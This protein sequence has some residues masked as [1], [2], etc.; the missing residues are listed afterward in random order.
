M[1]HNANNTV[2]LTSSCRATQDKNWSHRL[3]ECSQ[4][5]INSSLRVQWVE[6]PLNK[7]LHFIIQ[8]MIYRAISSH[9]SGPNK[10]FTI[11]YWHWKIGTVEDNKT[12]GEKGVTTE[13][14]R[15]NKKL[16]LT[17]IFYVPQK[18]KFQEILQK[19]LFL[20]VLCTC[21]FSNSSQLLYTSLHRFCRSPPTSFFTH[22]SFV[23]LYCSL[24]APKHT[25]NNTQYYVFLLP[26]TFT[27][28]TRL[29]LKVHD[30]FL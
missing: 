13:H 23:S 15:G 17:H 9:E 12:I 22:F 11:F 25:Y 1:S 18:G 16:F 27:V 5:E 24:Q 3:R 20:T 19:P 26:L 30:A 4:W 7:T 10:I 6:F 21:C 14:F 28:V 29:F 2:W 8:P